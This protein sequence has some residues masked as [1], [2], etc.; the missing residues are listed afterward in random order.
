MALIDPELRGKDFTAAGYERDKE[1]CTTQRGGTV[2]G[3]LGQTH[4]ERIVSKF[5]GGERPVPEFREH[6]W[7]G[8]GFA[9]AAP[10]STFAYLGWRL[11]DTIDLADR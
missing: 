4:R 2:H 9:F 3:R 7:K 6:Q 5:A 10:F 11:T 8:R 1:T